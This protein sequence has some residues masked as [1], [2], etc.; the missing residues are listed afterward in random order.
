ESVLD[1]NG[2]VS[3]PAGGR[4]EYTV[5]GLIDPRSEHGSQ[6]TF[7]AEAARADAAG[8]TWSDTD[9][10][11]TMQANAT[12]GL[13]KQATSIEAPTNQDDDYIIHYDVRITNLGPSYA[14]VAL[15]DP[16]SGSSSELDW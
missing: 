15:T 10:D 14:Q 3:I 2:T 12:L 9:D 5:N 6:I 4:V 13:Q 1:R 16:A 11:T 8:E 7:S